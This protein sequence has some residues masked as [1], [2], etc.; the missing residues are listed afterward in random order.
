MEIL[1]CPLWVGSCLSAPYLLRLTIMSAMGST[2][3][4]QLLLIFGP[5]TGS[6]RPA[7][8]I[9]TTGL[10]SEIISVSLLNFFQ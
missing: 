5:A 4:A 2:A 10:Y 8:D 6:S 9:E 3:D 7:A 1:Q